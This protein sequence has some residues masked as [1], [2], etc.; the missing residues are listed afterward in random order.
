MTEE[1]RQYLRQ[2]PAFPSTKGDSGLTLRQYFAIQ[3]YPAMLQL[4]SGD[5]AARHNV[6]RYCAQNAVAAADA[7]L[8]ELA[9]YG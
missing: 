7:L 3:M 2:K 4:C 6:L 9:E 5:E 1:L 8:E